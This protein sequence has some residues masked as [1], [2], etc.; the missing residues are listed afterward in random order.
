MEK[1]AFRQDHIVPAMPPDVLER[2]LVS[3]APPT[4]S[5]P[6]L[7]PL[8]LS[9]SSSGS[10]ASVPGDKT[11]SE[12]HE[13]VRGGLPDRIGK[14][15]C[16][17]RNFQVIVQGQHGRG[18][19]RQ[20]DTKAV[21]QAVSRLL[22][23]L[24]FLELVGVKG[25]V[26]INHGRGLVFL[27]GPNDMDGLDIGARGEVLQKALKH[28]IPPKCVDTNGVS[29]AVESAGAWGCREELNLEDCL[30]GK[31]GQAQD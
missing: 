4:C 7:T 30:E 2:A 20:Q 10:A 5:T 26:P 14:I 23:E 9:F 18:G 1:A 12:T 21:I 28:V 24:D 25:K 16:A 31:V 22:F 3:I 8:R 13:G 29:A 17:T 11:G 6:S 27:V 19:H 15:K